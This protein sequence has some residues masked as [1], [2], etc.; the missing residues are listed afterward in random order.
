ML[1][2]CPDDNLQGMTL[3]ALLRNQF[4]VQLQSLVYIP[5]MIMII[6]YHSS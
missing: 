6:S 2:L 5:R 3:T 1:G 4:K